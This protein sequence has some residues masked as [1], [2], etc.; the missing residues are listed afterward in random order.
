MRASS[1]SASV[2]AATLAAA[3]SAAGDD[4]DAT[5]LAVADAPRDRLEHEEHRAHRRDGERDPEAP[6]AEL[7]VRVHGQDHEQHPD[8]H[9]HR[10]LREHGEDEGL[11]QDAIGL[12]LLDPSRSLR[13]ARLIEHP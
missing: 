13:P 9:A 10:E 8:R 11:R 7:V 3:T 5:P 12:H 4:Q 2:Y 1:E 6:G